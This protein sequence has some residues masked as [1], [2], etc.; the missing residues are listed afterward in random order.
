MTNE[1]EVYFAL[2]GDDFDPDAFT[3]RSGLTPT[4]VCRKGES[5]MYVE[6]YKFGMWKISSGRIANDVLL[7]DEL[8]DQL[9]ESIEGA[10]DCIADAVRVAGLY[11]VLEVVLYISMNETLSTPALGFTSKTIAFLHKV[12]AE[13]DVDIYRNQG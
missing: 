1:V 5:G 3:M 9:I 2:K 7:V 6:K 4:E 12:R 13:I 8:A 10:A 11:A